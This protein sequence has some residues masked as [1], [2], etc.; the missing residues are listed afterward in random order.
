M[1]GPS[2]NNSVHLVDLFSKAEAASVQ[3]SPLGR[4]IAWLARSSGV[5]NIFLAP[6]PLPE[7]GGIASVARQ[8]TVA[9][10]R[11]ICF[12][13]RFTRDD[14]KIVYLR[15]HEHGSELYHLYSLDLDGVE[16]EGCDLLAHHP[17]L[18]CAVGFAGGLQLW[19]PTER[20]TTVIL[21]TGRG[22]LLWDL[23]E[24]DLESGALT[25]LAAN[26]TSSCL[27]LLAL[28]MALLAHAIVHAVTVLIDLLTLRLLPR[29]RAWLERLAPAPAATV[30][31]FVRAADGLVVGRAEAALSLPRRGLALRLSKRVGDGAWVA[32]CAD[33][34]FEH[35]NMQL[36]GS[37][38][39]SGTMRL[40]ALGDADDPTR[41][42]GVH[43][44]DVADTT[45]YV[46]YPGG[47]VLA[48]D[49]RA[50]ISGFVSHP[51]SGAVEAVEVTAARSELV[52]LGAAGERVLAELDRVRRA[53][54]RDGAGGD[55]SLELHLTSRTLRDDL[56]VVTAT[57]DTAAA[58]YYLHRPHVGHGGHGG[59]GGPAAPT[60]EREP[61]KLL[62]ARPRLERLPLVTTEALTITARDGERLPAYLTRPR[63]HDGV[64]GTRRPPLALV[65][66]GGPNARDVAG[67]DPLTQLL[68]ARGIGV[69]ALN[70]RGSTGYGARFYRL[71]MGH[72][73]GMHE[74][75]E[76]ARGWAIASGLADPERIAIVGGSWG[77]YLALGAATRIATD[78]PSVTPKPAFADDRR[79]PRYAAVVAI[80]PLVTVGAAN[81][82]AAFRGDPLIKQ[83]CLPRSPMI[84]H[85]LP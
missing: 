15:E 29:L 19:L 77:G 58:V 79:V 21:A 74:D 61:L 54:A 53:I 67:F 20:P 73:A 25:T 76:D 78:A 45:A 85:D 33:V 75:V 23:S 47:A 42:V 83:V 56:W 72:V 66:H 37:G 7:H 2:N 8:L 49:T 63:T 32:V 68:A 70:Y 80:V 11:D 30:Q 28:V 60:A 84:S 34:A 10:D 36:I 5:L 22:S 6:L 62:S 14:A 71:G 51:A 57:S 40:D 44:C 59:H 55:V 46:A 82:S 65:V 4:H 35:L 27:G 1:A 17:K 3:L 69:L 31:Y 41:R 9:T 39:A 13:F 16:R 38:G 26:P 43:V 24:L 18:T 48:N 64:P 50:D 52:P 12:C 81:T